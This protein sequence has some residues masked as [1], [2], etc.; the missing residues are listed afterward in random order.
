M[1][2]LSF[3][4]DTELKL[5][6]FSGE[7]LLLRE[8]WRITKGL[9][10]RSDRLR[11][12]R[13]VPESPAGEDRPLVVMEL[14]L[15]APLFPSPPPPAAPKAAPRPSSGG[16]S[17]SKEVLRERSGLRKGDFMS[18]M[19]TIV[20]P[21]TMLSGLIF[22]RGDLVALDK[23]PEEDDT[24]RA[25]LVGVAMMALGAVAARAKLADVAL[26]EVAGAG[27][28]GGATEDRSLLP[29]GLERASISAMLSA[30]ITEG[31]CRLIFFAAPA[32][33]VRRLLLAYPT[34]R[35]LFQAIYTGS[36][37]GTTCRRKTAE[38][39]RCWSSSVLES[40]EEA[41]KSTGDASLRFQGESRLR[42]CCLLGDDSIMT[43]H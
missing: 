26:G 43:S 39:A 7:G 35:L 30:V 19:L 22:L 25:A 2:S 27:S 14:D 29:C 34:R 8:G 10:F 38:K 33:R 28:A 42:R 9:L 37:K 23:D 11:W 36:R 18:P 13:L 12:R 17:D 32:A 6:A 31:V 5:N 20:L 3:S 21:P 1:Y 15:E 4:G 24:D 41:R 40:C 16:L